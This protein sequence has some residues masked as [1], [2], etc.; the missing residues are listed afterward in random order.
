MK[1]YWLFAGD[2]YYPGGG[3]ED[4][5]ASFDTVEEANADQSGRKAD[6]CQILDSATGSWCPSR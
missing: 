1:R 3:M 5:I 2:A 4:F 6:W